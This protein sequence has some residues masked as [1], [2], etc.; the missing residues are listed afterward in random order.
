MLN[1]KTCFLSGNEGGDRCE[2]GKGVA[3]RRPAPVTPFPA[4]FNEGKKGGEIGFVFGLF[5]SE[6]HVLS[7]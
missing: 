2:A 5:I 6:K 4:L 7:G 3:G 1:A